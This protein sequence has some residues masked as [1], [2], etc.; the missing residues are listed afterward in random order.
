MDDKAHKSGLTA[1]PCTGQSVVTA[2]DEARLFTQWSEFR[3]AFSDLRNIKSHFPSIP[4]MCL[5]A[6]A[7]PAV[8]EDIEL[9]FRNPVVQKMSM[10]RP[11]FTLN[12]EELKEV[13]PIQTVCKKGR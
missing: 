5:T 8:E 10:N 9:L 12:V 1:Y 4:I 7:T 2:I 6:T 13:E 11:N 3:T